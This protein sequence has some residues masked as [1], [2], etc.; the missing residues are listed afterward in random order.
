MFFI[1]FYF[2]CA[3]VTAKSF[4]YY[5]CSDLKGRPLYSCI[6][7]RRVQ[8]TPPQNF[9]TEPAP[10]FA[11]QTRKHKSGKSSPP[12]PL[13][14]LELAAENSSKQRDFAAD[15]MGKKSKKSTDEG[16][17]VNVGD[18]QAAQ[19]FSIPPS[20]LPVKLDTSDWP[21]LLKVCALNVEQFNDTS[22]AEF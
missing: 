1:L 18:V 11:I 3:L 8:S 14:S 6:V 13:D 4:Y 22:I 19:A 7:P 2:V 15:T 21:L 10:I 20:S 17:D 16:G 12:P 9:R 5:S